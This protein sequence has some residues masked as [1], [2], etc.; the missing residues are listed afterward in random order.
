MRVKRQDERGRSFRLTKIVPWIGT[1]VLAFV[2]GVLLADADWSRIAAQRAWVWLSHLAVVPQAIEYRRDIDYLRIDIGFE[3]YQRLFAQGRTGLDGLRETRVQCALAEVT[4]DDAFQGL[5][6]SLCR[7]EGASLTLRD[8][9]EALDMA[10]LVLAPARADAVF[11]SHYSSFLGAAGLPAIQPSYLVSLHVNGSR[12]GLYLV[13]AA[14]SIEA[15]KGGD[16]GAGSVIV[17]YS[18]LV[19]P[20]SADHLVYKSRAPF[21]DVEVWGSEDIT[22]EATVQTVAS[23]PDLERA[24]AEAVALLRALGRGELVPSSILDPDQL[25]AY[26]AASAWWGGDFELTRH[27]LYLAYD[28]VVGRF[29]PIVSGL[30]LSRPSGPSEQL[31][32]AFKDDPLVQRA[33][34]QR[35]AQLSATEM[36]EPSDQELLDAAY[37]ALM[38]GLDGS[39]LPSSV[40]AER[41]RRVAELI[42]PERPLVVEFAEAQQGILLRAENAVRFPVQ[43]VAIECEE[44]A[45][46]AVKEAWIVPDKTDA[47][48]VPDQGTV[49]RARTGAESAVAY[50]AVPPDASPLESCDNPADLRVVARIW[51]LDDR[52]TVSVEPGRT[53]AWWLSDE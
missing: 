7:G 5:T 10:P 34:A 53:D 23:S 17:S 47:A 12:W 32:L 3:D 31:P 28:P 37:L 21:A 49:L 33:Y 2:L 40:L 50:L 45:S 4:L 25:G 44:R 52:I 15:L 18:D 24:G 8:D 22:G 1:V 41:R 36:T 30:I 43:I 26:W 38:S 27:H 14:P 16:F 46:E 19:S 39:A 48:L 29:T 11:G 20:L 35:L 42:S 51:G 6:L 13:E 9:E